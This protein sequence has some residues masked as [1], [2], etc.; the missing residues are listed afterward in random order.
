[1]ICFVINNMV[2]GVDCDLNKSKMSSPTLPRCHKS[3]CYTMTN[4]GAGLR[5]P[6]GLFNSIVEIHVRVDSEMS[7]P[8]AGV[9]G[10][11]CTMV[12]IVL[13]CWRQLTDERNRESGDSNCSIHWAKVQWKVATWVHSLGIGSFHKVSCPLYSRWKLYY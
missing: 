1:M 6:L 13:I 9:S 5:M 2:D 11:S 10:E 3:S 7:F 8:S 4:I 12:I